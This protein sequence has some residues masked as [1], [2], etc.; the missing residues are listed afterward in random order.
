MLQSERRNR[1]S[2][3]QQNRPPFERIS[4]RA[5]RITAP[6]IHIIHIPSFQQRGSA[7]LGPIG[8][9]PVGKIEMEN[10]RDDLNSLIHETMTLV[11]GVRVEPPLPR[12]IVEPN[13]TPSVNWR[14]SEREEVGQ[15]VANFKAHQQRF[16][17]DREDFVAA[18][19]MRMRA[20]QHRFET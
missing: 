16:L 7:G 12:T 6:V 5:R 13:R 1:G 18:E 2:T 9:R 10:W 17:R 3:S 19:W 20:S 4:D 14:L 8:W 11:K 15:R